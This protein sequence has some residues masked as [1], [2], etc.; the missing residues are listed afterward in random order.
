MEALQLLSRS[1]MR[2][3]KGGYISEGCGIKNAEGEWT[4][5]WSVSQ[6]QSWYTNHDG[7]VAYC[8]ASCGETGFSSSPC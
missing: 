3:V 2:N 5:G 1:E 8:C 4:C 7:I 6:A